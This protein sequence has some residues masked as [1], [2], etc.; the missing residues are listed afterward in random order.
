M[1]AIFIFETLSLFSLIIFGG[2]PDSKY[3]ERKPIKYLD[4]GTWVLVGF[5]MAM[6]TL[7]A[8]GDLHTEKM[9]I[10]WH[11]VMVCLI[12]YSV[13]RFPLLHLKYARQ[14]N[15]ARCFLF[16]TIVFETIAIVIGS[17]EYVL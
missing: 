16:S 12:C 3:Y 15:L 9:R 10:V 1:D 13:Y 6:I 17:W 8:E 2:V 11:S 4:W 7:S 5:V 14:Y